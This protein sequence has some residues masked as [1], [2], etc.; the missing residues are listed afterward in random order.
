MWFFDNDHGSTSFKGCPESLC[1]I[2]YDRSFLNESSLVLF[3]SRDFNA[4][5]LP[6]HRMQDQRF[7]FMSMESPA[8]SMMPMDRSISTMFNLTM[9]YMSSS[10]IVVKYGDVV[11]RK[12]PFPDINYAKTKSRGTLWYVSNCFTEGSIIR[13]EFVKDLRQLV[14]VDVF[15]LCGDPDPCMLNIKK[16]RRR[17]ATCSKEMEKSYRFYL[18]MENS[19]CVDYITEKFW[20]ALNNDMVPIVMGASIEEYQ[21]VAPPLSFIHVNQ[22]ASVEELSAHLIYLQVNDDAY[23][24]YMT[25]KRNFTV[26][27]NVFLS[28][29]LCLLCS[30]AQQRAQHRAS[31][32]LKEWWNEDKLCRKSWR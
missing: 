26:R 27:Q 23:N 25:W 1:N 9:T 22:F 32:S 21:K 31:Y 2:T 6:D 11:R 4:K 12:T 15:G 19:L 13:W 18:A 7:T 8:N 16:M 30:K 5:D 14:D 24:Q 29:I 20:Y 28:E 17:N 3:H 10:D